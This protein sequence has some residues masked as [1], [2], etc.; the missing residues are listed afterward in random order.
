MRVTRARRSTAWTGGG[1]VLVVLLLAALPY[2]VYANVTDLL[3]NLFI[4]L[5]I[6]T[7]W[8]LLAGYAGLISVGQQAYLGVGAYVVLVLGDNGISPFIGIPLAALVAAIVAIPVSVPLLRLRNEYFAIATWVVAEAFR[9]IVLRFPSLG[10]GTGATL[11]GL[12]DFD[13]SVREAFTYWAALAVVVGAIVTTYFLLRSRSGM[14]LTAIRDNEI[15]ARS[16]GVRTLWAK[17]L[18]YV[19]AAAGTGA[20]GSLLIISQLNVQ[21]GSIF[22]VQWSA[23]M[24]F[25]ALIGGLG[26]IEGPILGTVVFFALQQS[27]ADRGAWYLIV[28][29]AIAVAFALW[30]PRGIWGLITSRFD[31]RLFPVGYWLHTGAPAARPVDAGQG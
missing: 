16:I 18:A 25:V 5:T 3:V 4:L 14:D 2:L 6:A 9:L 19:V 23:Y 26:S 8:N 7:M 12:A 11:Q 31:L 13:P 28:L 22:S 27:L 1:A 29:G 20:A 15:G 24:I 17:R 10:G 30:V 21:A